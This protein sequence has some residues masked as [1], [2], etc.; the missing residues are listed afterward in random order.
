MKKIISL[1]VPTRSYEGNGIDGEQTHTVGINGIKEIQEHSARGEGDKWFYDVI[2][3][4]GS[5]VRFFEFL[6]VIMIEE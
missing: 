3:N 6:R 4:D 1:V 2:Y 5:I